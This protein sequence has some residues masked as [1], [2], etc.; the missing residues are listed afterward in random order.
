M[1]SPCTS[2][3]AATDSESLAWI[4][5]SAA[6]LAALAFGSGDGKITPDLTQLRHLALLPGDAL[7]LDLDDPTQRRFG[8]Y[9]LLE[10]IGQG[11]MGVVYRARQASLDREVA[12]KLLAAGPWASRDFIERFQLEAR[13]AARMQ[14]PNIVAIYE[15]G[16]AEGL[17]FFSMRLVRGQSL[18]AELSANGPFEVRRAARMLRTVAEAV[19]YA[20]SLGVLHL[21]LKP[22]NVLLDEN[23][24]PLVADF[25][26]ARRVDGAL[27]LEN[28]EISGT[29]AYMA[30]EQAEAHTGTISAATDVWGLGAIL[31]EL[32]TGEP[33]FR[34][35]TAYDTLQRI[36]ECRLTRP[37][38]LAPKLPADFEAIV[39]KCLAKD[40]ADRYESAR[41]LADDLGRFGE[42]RAVEARPLNAP[43]K[44]VRWILREPR[45]ALAST[46]LVA[47][48]VGGLVATTREWRRAEGNAERAEAVRQFLAGVFEHASPDEN[49]GQ[50]FTAHQL[51]EIGEKQLAADSGAHPAIEADITSLLGR[52]YIGVSDFQRS[53]ILLQRA[54][55]MLADLRVPDDVRA[56]VFLGMALIENESG[57]YDAALTHAKASLALLE[58]ASTRNPQDIASAHLVTASAL[59]RK[60]DASAERYLRAS[61]AG[62]EKALGANNPSVADQEVQLGNLLARHGRFDE[63]EASFRRAIAA[64]TATYGAVSNGV[65]HALNEMSNMLEDKGDLAGAEAALNEALRIR[66]ATVGPDHHDTIAVESNLFWLIE[67]EG[68][69]EEA[70]P[71]RLALLDRATRAGQLHEQDRATVLASLGKDYR[72]L[73]RFDDAVATLRDAVAVVDRLEGSGSMIAAPIRRQLGLAEMLTGDYAAA[74][75]T[76]RATLEVMRAHDPPTTP[77]LNFLRADI[78][79]LLRLQHKVAESLAELVAAN[80]AL[81]KISTPTNMSRPLALSELALTEIEAG[82]VEAASRTADDALDYARKA[83][84][85]NHYMLGLPLFAVGSARLAAGRAGDAEPLLREALRV[86]T[87]PH[88]ESDPRVLE[89]KVALV[90]ALTRLGER[91]EA[92]RLRTQVEAEL[93]TLRTPYGADLRR[94]LA[95]AGKT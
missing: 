65:A 53:E 77:T 88:P 72:E 79:K 25:G 23:G 12:L 58:S 56:R 70:V 54:H 28:E 30:P 41:Q 62:D 64:F 73:G 61:L 17:H 82:D 24:T 37:R 94:R 43:Q 10:L 45:L 93:R 86:R 55:A 69:Y 59:V 34:A 16:E 46:L 33:P 6:A 60:G 42:G 67:Y 84:P 75:R 1:A 80:E 3:A 32:S 83:Y 51:L 5:A 14:H 87:P 92:Q 68:R 8:D 49:K 52:L 89:V 48:L 26:L 38:A 78:G 95:D 21:D 90:A 29:P 66:M 44:I 27:V 91:D 39:L 85:A 63:A 22:G 47:A 76:L 9:E 36:I 40:P 57:S 35:A 7:D 31:Y 20:H 4:D 11:G 15:T 50:P 74:E 18:A 81:A 19:A 2:L 71:R 13:N